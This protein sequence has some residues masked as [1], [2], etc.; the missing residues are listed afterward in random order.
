[1]TDLEILNRHL[2]TH[3]Y[4]GIE[5]WTVESCFDKTSVLLVDYFACVILAMHC[6][7]G[8][9]I[10][11][12]LSSA[13][14]IMTLCDLSHLS[15]CVCLRLPDIHPDLVQVQPPVPDT[16]PG[17]PQ[18]CLSAAKKHNVCWKSGYPHCRFCWLVFHRL[19]ETDPPRSW[20][21]IAHHFRPN[22]PRLTLGY[23]I[24]TPQKDLMH[25]SS[26]DPSI[27]HKYS[28]Y[29]LQLTEECLQFNSLCFV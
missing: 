4:I 18:H 2:T 20:D 23:L 28:F 9:C 13:D 19:S 22:V 16:L 10:C 5:Y 17:Y 11:S 6:H 14:C 24:A 21:A 29:V 26:H 25:R 1:M 7:M 8:P 27:S 15:H 3:E 12:A